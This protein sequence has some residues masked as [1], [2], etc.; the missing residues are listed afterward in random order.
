MP[1]YKLAMHDVSMS[2]SSVQKAHPEIRSS[3][4]SRIMFSWFFPLVWKGFR[5]PI[6]VKDLWDLSPVDSCKEIVPAVNKHWQRALKNA[7]R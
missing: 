2:C 7:E 1:A 4:L 6:E 3:Y 5:H